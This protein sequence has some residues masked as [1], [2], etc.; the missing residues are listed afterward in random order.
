MPHTQG[1]IKVW[2]AKPS[3]FVV[4][5]IRA[6]CEWPQQRGVVALPLKKDRFRADFQPAAKPLPKLTLDRAKR[7]AYNF[8][9]SLTAFGNL[10]HDRRV[11]GPHAVVQ[12]LS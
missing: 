10:C 6:F 7:R 2:K 4:M 5:R 9:K 12:V 3:C 8:A 11:I 1:T